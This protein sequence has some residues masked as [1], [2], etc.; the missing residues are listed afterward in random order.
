MTLLELTLETA[1]KED[2]KFR[3]VRLLKEDAEYVLALLKKQE[4]TFEKDGHHIMCKSCGAYFC[5]R[6]REGDQYPQNFCPNCGKSVKWNEANLTEQDLAEKIYW[7]LIEEGQRNLKLPLGSIITNTPDEV[8]DIIRKHI[9]E[10][11]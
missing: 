8:R 2:G 11:T 6:D 7:I 9:K 4:T 10:L 3:D 5:D 1:I